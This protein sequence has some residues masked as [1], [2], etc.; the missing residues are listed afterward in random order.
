MLCTVCHKNIAA[1]S[2]ACPYCHHAVTDE[3]RTPEAQD[4]AANTAPSKSALDTMNTVGRSMTKYVTSSILIVLG[5]V[6][7]FASPIIGVVFIVIGILAAC[8]KL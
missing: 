4:R 8:I 7:L 1:N 5:I 3:D 2:D 6:L